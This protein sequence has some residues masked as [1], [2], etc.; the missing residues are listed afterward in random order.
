M[1]LNGDGRD[2][3]LVLLT[4]RRHCGT[5]GCSLVVFEGTADGFRK[6]SVSTIS[7]EPVSLLEESSHGWH[8]FTLWVSGGGLKSHAV[9]MRFTGT[10]Y[11]GNSSMQPAA[12]VTGRA[13][14]FRAWT[15]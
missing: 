15:P 13:L 12:R 11:L 2:D 4:D 14:E 3:A 5:G 9:R 8:S 10:R 6:L 1:D 7:R